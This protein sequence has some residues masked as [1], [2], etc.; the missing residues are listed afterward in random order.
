MEEQ[1]Q[2][3]RTVRICDLISPAITRHMVSRDAPPAPGQRLGVSHDAFRFIKIQ[4]CDQDTAY[5]V[6]MMIEC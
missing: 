5:I 3:I 2:E 6:Y 4:G 1:N